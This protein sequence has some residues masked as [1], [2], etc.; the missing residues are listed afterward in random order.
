LSNQL[1]QRNQALW[2][3]TVTHPFVLELGAGTLPDEKFRRYFLQDFIF[4]RDLA[5][6]ISLIT[7]KAPELDT[8]RRLTRFLGDVLGGEESLF[9]QTFRGWGLAPAEY[10]H[11]EALPATRAFGDFLVRTGYERGFP[12][13]LACLVVSEWSYLDWA[14]RLARA[15]NAPQVPAYRGWI[16]VHSNK[17]FT[18]FVAW[19]RR[20]LDAIPLDAGQ[21]ARVGEVFLTCLRYEHRFWEMAYRGEE[22]VG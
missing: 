12:E 17:G 16:E 18:G 11:A 13:A 5:K 4:V 20:R 22:W 10:L 6:L 9:R 7:A 14:A 19:L 2:E 1:R 3:R 21:R 8:A 15:G